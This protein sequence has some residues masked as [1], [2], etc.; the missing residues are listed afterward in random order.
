MKGAQR[1]GIGLG[2]FTKGV[3]I[4]SMVL[5]AQG[6]FAISDDSGQVIQERKLIPTVE[7][8]NFDMVSFSLWTKHEFHER[9][10]DRAIKKLSESGL[11]KKTRGAEASSDK[12]IILKL[13][14][15]PIPL[16]EACPEKVLYVKN[17]ELIEEVVPKRNPKILIPFVVTWSYGLPTPYITDDVSID[18]LEADLDALLNVFI[19]SYKMGNPKK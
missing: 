17:L 12:N 1:R 6:G 9:L 5:V 11:Y 3:I 13:I 18:Q 10:Y 4:L 16:E 7:N 15:R 8:L 19:M 14:L 2:I